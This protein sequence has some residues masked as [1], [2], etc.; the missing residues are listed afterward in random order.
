MPFG[1]K[2]DQIIVG[3]V[4][5]MILAM[6]G[7]IWAEANSHASE[8]ALKTEI[9]ARIAADTELKRA[10]AEL[11]KEVADYIRHQERRDG[12]VDKLLEQLEKHME[13]ER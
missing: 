13:L 7:L 6:G 8:D 12:K 4:S 10:Q 5:T 2:T 9:R 1:N 3:V 11:T